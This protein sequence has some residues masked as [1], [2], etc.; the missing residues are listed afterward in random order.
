V[1]AK[2]NTAEL[3]GIGQKVCEEV[4]DSEMQMIERDLKR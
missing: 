4:M 2:I 1:K 3:I